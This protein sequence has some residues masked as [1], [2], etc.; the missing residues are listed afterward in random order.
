MHE[1]LKASFDVLK[2]NIHT[3]KKCVD[4]NH[5]SERPNSTLSSFHMT[6]TIH[7]FV[8]WANP[9]RN[10]RNFIFKMF[11]GMVENFP[12]QLFKP[13]VVFPNG[14]CKHCAQG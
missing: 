8:E 5:Y 13:L 4:L 2:R 12:I 9:T 6:Q 7:D 3:T 11:L 1:V 14:H 10:F